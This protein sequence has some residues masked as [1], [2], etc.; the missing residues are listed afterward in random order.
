[1]PEARSSADW[2]AIRNYLY[3]LMQH[4]QGRVTLLLPT[5][6]PTTVQDMRTLASGWFFEHQLSETLRL[7]SDALRDASGSLADAHRVA[8]AI[9]VSAPSREDLIQVGASLR[10]LSVFVK[11]DQRAAAVSSFLATAAETLESRPV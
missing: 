5:R 8:A 10:R 6:P 4:A 2:D 11:R 9:V 7:T 1:M 3:W